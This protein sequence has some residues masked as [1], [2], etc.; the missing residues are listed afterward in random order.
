MWLN[1]FQHDQ[2]PK[3]LHDLNVKALNYRYHKK[4]YDRLKGEE[5]QTLDMDFGNSPDKLKRKYLDN[6]W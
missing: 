3:T 1:M 2:D 6:V 4:L 5:R